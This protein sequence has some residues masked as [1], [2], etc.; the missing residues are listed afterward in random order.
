M[1]KIA[2][3]DDNLIFLQE[4]KKEL[5]LLLD[6]QNIEYIIKEYW[7][8]EALLYEEEKENFHILILDIEMEGISGIEVAECIRNRDSEKIIIFVTNQEML[9]FESIKYAPFRFLRKQYMHIE[10]EEAVMELSSNIKL[11]NKVYT[12]SMN[13]EIIYI[14]VQDIFYFESLEHKI[15]IHSKDGVYYTRDRLK[16]LEKE[17]KNVG[18]IRVHSG[19]LVNQKYIFR[20]KKK[21]IVL[22]N[23]I[24][25][26]LSRHR[27][28]EV[29]R[30]IMLHKRGIY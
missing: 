11:E 22:S 23:N 29:K 15:M 14:K 8:G 9:V 28:D 2:I 18:F 19:Y 20:I 3:C 27:V 4:F 6:A 5:S 13:G 30:F 12:F 17:L 25:L 10:L 1:I 26:P 16:K 24:I 7:S 21:D